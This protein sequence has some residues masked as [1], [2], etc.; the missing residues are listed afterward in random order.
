[1][2]LIG[3]LAPDEKSRRELAL[4]IEELGHR[5][6]Q[7]IQLREAVE[8]LGQSSL[9]LMIVAPQ[10]DDLKLAESVL[11]ESERQRP[12]LPVV[13]ATAKRDAA[14]AVELMRAGAYEVVTPPWTRENISACLSKAL[15]F[16]GTSFDVLEPRPKTRHAITYFAA[17]LAF[18]AAA[19]GYAIIAHRQRAGEAAKARP[20]AEWELPYSHPSGLAFHKG[21]LWTADWHSQT[22]HRHDP[23]TMTLKR[24]LHLPRLT[25]RAIAVSSDALWMAS[26]YGSV[27]RHMLD[28][29]LTQLSKYSIVPNTVGLAYDGLYLWTLDGKDDK[30]RKHLL[31]DRLTVIDEFAY[32]GSRPAAITFDGR[33]LWSVDAGNKE[34]LRHDIDDPKTITWRVS[35]REY[36]SGRWL[37]SGLA[38]D[39][40]RFWTTAEPI[41]R[42]GPVGTARMFKHIDAALS[43]R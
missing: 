11:A 25:P 43:A 36:Q 22:I 38:W 4:A 5:V 40:K 8:I 14:K 1:M 29:K 2:A 19:F 23:E 27:T 41:K 24:S 37:P 42:K 7:A 12:L 18:F 32:P 16:Q 6:S 21:E 30:V 39:G 13:V 34:L 20:Q 31:D 33:T 9:Q 35:L 15:R 3:L 26:V 28:E 17:A 10:G